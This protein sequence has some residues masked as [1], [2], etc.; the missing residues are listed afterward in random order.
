VYQ[1]EEGEREFLIGSTIRRKM[2]Q[3][4]Q[5]TKR[6]RERKEENIMDRSRMIRNHFSASC[7]QQS[8]SSA[9]TAR[10][11]GTKPTESRGREGEWRRKEAKR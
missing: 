3:E 2:L 1:E 7:C 6:E 9:N 8:S 4:K 10:L 11:Y 5:S